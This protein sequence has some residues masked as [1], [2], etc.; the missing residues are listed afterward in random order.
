LVL[1]VVPVAVDRGREMYV[2]KC[3]DIVAS[4]RSTSPLAA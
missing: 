1:S 2:G 4:A 3:R